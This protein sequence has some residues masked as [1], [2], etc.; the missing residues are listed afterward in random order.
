MKRTLVQSQFGNHAA[1]YAVSGVHAKGWSLERLVALVAPQPGE[2][3]LD[4]ATGAGHTAAAFAPLVDSVIASDITEEMLTEAARLAQR[5]S[6]ANMQIAVADAELLPFPDKSFD[7]V[8]C[9][10]A[11]HH[12]PHPARF[13]AEA[14]R[15]LRPGGRL[16]VVDNISP[17]GE[18]L[19]GVAAGEI[20]DTA[21]GYN[22]FEALRDPSHGRALSVAEWLVLIGEAGLAITA[23]ERATKDMDFADYVR[24]MGCDEATVERLGAMLSSGLAPLRAFLAPRMI[25]GA[26][27]FHLHEAVIVASKQA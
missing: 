6:L 19:P 5:R 7:I 13:V 22:A 16:G 3:A 12:F 24:R 20:A 9:R 25:D 15:V 2:R 27:V 11:A 17:D 18:A 14:A 21:A 4:I 26:L 8:L 23:A 1:A 10:L